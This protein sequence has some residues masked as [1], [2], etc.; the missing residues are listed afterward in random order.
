M[1]IETQENYKP[2]TNVIK[3]VGEL[4]EDERDSLIQTYRSAFEPPPYC[5]QFTK[6]DVIN[7]FNMIAAKDGEVVIILGEWT[8][9]YSLSAGFLQEDGSYWI[10]EL[11]TNPDYQH[12]GYGTMALSR[13]KQIAQGKGASIIETRTTEGNRKALSLYN[14]A[15]FSDTGE[16]V[17]VAR[18]R[19]DGQ[20]GTD[21]RMYLRKAITKDYLPK[22]K[23][24][25]VIIAYPSGNPTALVLD[26]IHENRAQELN[27]KLIQKF[28]EVEQGGFIL[29]TTQKDCVGRIGMFGGEFCGNAARAAVWVLTQ[30]NFGAGNLEFEVGGKPKVL[31]YEVF[32]DGQVEVEMPLPSKNVIEKRKEGILVRLAGISH[33]I[34]DYNPGEVLSSEELKSKARTILGRN[35]LLREPAAGVMFYSKELSTVEPVVWVRDMETYFYETACG[36]GT[37]AIGVAESYKQRRSVEIAVQ[38]PSGKII[39]VSAEQ[40][41]AS[42]FSAKIK[43]A[44]SELYRGNVNLANP[45]DE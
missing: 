36:S 17:L 5:E 39:T 43:G 38:Q 40:N 2:T 42:V 37:C 13:L 3:S 44:V 16:R 25:S 7:T 30:G 22:E 6:E 12:Q 20:P 10:E 45:D 1:K 32:E 28:P 34:I 11:A 41:E 23:L 27:D 29:P 4:T 19:T 9:V 24:R 26:Q 15:V 31:A 8:N 21:I 33:L 14:E 18:K 35:N